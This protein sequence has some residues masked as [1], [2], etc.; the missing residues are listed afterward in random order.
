MEK[1]LDGDDKMLIKLKEQYHKSKIISRE[2]TEIGF[3][4]EFSVPEEFSVGKFRGDI[5]DVMSTFS[6]SDKMC[7]FRLTVDNGKLDTLEGYIMDGK[8]DC[9]DYECAS[10]EYTHGEKRKYSIREVLG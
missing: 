6:N 7:G 3:F 1:L 10:L 2:F 9:L 4:T 8:W 5:F